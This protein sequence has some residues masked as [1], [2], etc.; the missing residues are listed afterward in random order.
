MRVGF[1][2]DEEPLS[3]FPSVVASQDNDKRV[4]RS[5]RY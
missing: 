2:G 4:R 5:L 3:V 1:V